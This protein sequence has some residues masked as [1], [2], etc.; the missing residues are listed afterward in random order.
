[1]YDARNPQ[2][3]NDLRFA[4]DVLQES[5]HLGLDSEYT[6]KLQALIQTQIR[7][8]EATRDPR[9]PIGKTEAPTLG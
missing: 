5:S 2:I 6:S 3:A 8:R 1:M 9:L 7:R 4:L